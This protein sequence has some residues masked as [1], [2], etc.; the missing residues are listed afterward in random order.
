MNLLVT[1][2]NAVINPANNDIAN[3]APSNLSSG[4]SPS[5]SKAVANSNIDAPNPIS[6][7]ADPKPPYLFDSA[8]KAVIVPII[9]V[10][11]AIAFPN[12]LVSI[13]DNTN[14]DAAT[15]PIPIPRSF[16]VDGFRLFSAPLSPSVIDPIADLTSPAMS[17]NGLKISKNLS[18]YPVNDLEN[19]VSLVK[20]N[21]KPP[22][23]RIPFTTES[24]GIAF[25]I[26]PNFCNKLL[27]GLRTP[28][29]SNTPDNP[30]FKPFILLN[31][32]STVLDKLSTKFLNESNF[33]V[34][35]KLAI[36]IATIPTAS[37]TF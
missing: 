23:P 18:M 10:N 33:K 31:T 3:E 5:F 14:N 1:R 6:P 9:R 4:I 20:A 15:K 24:H 8:E 34:R 17:P 37:A 13:D 35:I 21:T 36:F 2:E 29:K 26:S 16:Q 30:F 32:F 11:A 25:S 27:V 19:F 12:L 22:P 7:F 28:L